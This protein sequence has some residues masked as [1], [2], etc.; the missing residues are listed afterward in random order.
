VL[1][2]VGSD[3]QALHMC[4]HIADEVVFTKNGANPQQPWILMKLPEMLDEYETSRP[5]EIQIYLRKT[6]PPMTAVHQL[7]SAADAL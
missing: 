3:H 2:L 1:L 7:S 5:Y 6:P 4:V